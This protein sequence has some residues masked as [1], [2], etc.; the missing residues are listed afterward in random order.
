MKNILVK[1]RRDDIPREW[2]IGVPKYSWKGKE[3]LKLTEVIDNSGNAYNIKQ[4]SICQNT[5]LKDSMSN[6][7]FEND[8]LEI[9]YEDETPKKWVVCFNKIMGM[10]RLK[11]YEGHG[12]RML[13]PLNERAVII[14][15]IKDSK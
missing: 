1:A 13:F 7:I 14:G 8:I 5:F 15:N 9:N 2:V 10:F 12:E 11:M 4:R 6:E 3:G